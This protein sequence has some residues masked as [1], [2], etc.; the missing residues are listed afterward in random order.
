[1]NA[2]VDDTSLAE[3]PALAGL[4]LAVA[5]HYDSQAGSMWR[6]LSAG[7]SRDWHS[8]LSLANRHGLGPLLYSAIS[9]NV[10][11]DF[12]P[13]IQSR[14]K[15]Q[16]QLTATM[17]MLAMHD[18]NAI[19]R[20]LRKAGIQAALLKGAALLASVFDNQAL[21]P[22]VD[23]D[24]LIRF[25]DLPKAKI[26][27]AGIG[28]TNDEPEPFDNPDGLYWNELLLQGQGR[29][30]AQLELHW[31]LLD[32]PYYATRLSVPS[33]FRRATQVD[34]EDGRATALS[35]EDLLLHLCAHNL[36]HHQGLLWRS[37]VDI[38]FVVNAHGS[39][40]DWDRFVASAVELDL[41]LG[42]KH[43]LA[44][45][46]GLWFAPIPRDVLATLGRL[47][48]KS[49]ERFWAYCQRSEF[50]KLFRTL[51]TLPGGRRRYNFMKGQ[52]LPSREYLY[53][54]YGTPIS[55]PAP[56]AYARRYTSGLR[57]LLAELTGRES[58]ES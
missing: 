14:L 41:L 7:G 4:R 45:A 55:S 52:L 36:Y 18:L 22:M 48:P 42:V 56:L 39:L 58:G 27:L 28:Y 54:R 46:A 3:Q 35:P 23:L 15:R 50:L 17:N 26:A 34:V 24:L 19:L 29:T 25:E 33:L 8:I 38:A 47:K 13:E 2:T 11:A 37:E 6:D 5:S 44:R 9:A 1:M 53:W 49:R 21:R 57:G 12:P 30:S 16:Y 10:P 31:N 32:I 51:T 20:S 43:S 40:L